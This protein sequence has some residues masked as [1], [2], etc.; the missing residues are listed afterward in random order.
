MK[1]IYTKYILLLFALS[2]TAVTS[3]SKVE[4]LKD[5]NL[6][7][8]PAGAD[9]KDKTIWEWLSVEQA[10]DLTGLAN[11]AEA[12]ERAGLIDTL[13]GAGDFT[14]VLARDE[15]VNLMVNKLGF[16]QVADVPGPILKNL[17]LDNMF[18]GRIHSYDLSINETKKYTTL[19]GSDIYI[20]RETD[21]GD[22]Y[23]L[24]VN[25]FPDLTSPSK[26]PVRTQN[27]EFKNGIVHIVDQFTYFQLASPA[28]DAPDETLETK[29]DTLWV[30]KDA[31]MRGRQY[32]DQNFNEDD[33][34]IKNN[35]GGQGTISTD[36][37]A[38]MQYPL[39]P[40]SFGS[41]IG[42]AKL[43]IHIAQMGSATQ[44]YSISAYKLDYI[45]VDET[46]VTWNLL[47]DF[48]HR[49]GIL[50][51]PRTERGWH[52]IDATN[53][54]IQAINAGEE[55]INVGYDH[56]SVD[57]VTVSAREKSNGEF[58]S[59]I[60][61]TSPPQTVLSLAT[62][63]TLVLD[64]N[65]GMAEIGTTHLKMEGTASKNILFTV[66]QPPANG[67]LVRY[68]FLLQENATFS[69]ADMESGAVKYLYDGTANSDLLVLEARDNNGGYFDPLINL[70]IEIK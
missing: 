46:A 13:N 37:R 41:K 49:M 34:L 42:T 45:D 35:S 58:R 57:M 60:S 3:C 14:I 43:N 28:P 12:V 68:G 52:A 40:A 8:I 59:F 65:N 19:N 56:P 30:S 23:L 9:L 16:Q 55:F 15:A 44:N 70:N 6:E 29:K 21:E 18:R 32:R 64:K 39:R 22:E 63:N 11:I 1:S 36:R 7:S 27:L 67:Y 26:V 17:L 50:S 24:Y 48:I 62:H 69:Q 47:P 20:T 53:D 10:K 54:I 33:V 51:V 4:L 5:I 25:N 38:F 66:V 31:Y 61:L 2:I